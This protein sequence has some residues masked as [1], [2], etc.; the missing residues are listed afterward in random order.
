MA[1][2]FFPESLGLSGSH[3]F[4]ACTGPR[5]I[6]ASHAWPIRQIPAAFGAGYNHHPHHLPGNFD[7]GASRFIVAEGWL[8]ESPPQT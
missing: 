3:F 1:H 7:A 4:L 2:P 6:P 5:E 8:N